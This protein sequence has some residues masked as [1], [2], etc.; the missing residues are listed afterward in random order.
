[1]AGFYIPE[2]AGMM[3]RRDARLLDARYAQSSLNA[4]LFSGALRTPP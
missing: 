2:F 4:E 1:M 3:P